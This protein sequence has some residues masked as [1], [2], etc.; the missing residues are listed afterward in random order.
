MWAPF[1]SE[2][3]WRVAQW[4]KMRGPGSNAFTELLEI[5]GV[6]TSVSFLAG[7][8]LILKLAACLGLSYTN[9]KELND[10]IDSHLP[11]RPEFKREEIKVKGEIFEIFYRDVIECVKALFGDEEL[12]PFI[13]L[14]PEKHYKDE[15]MSEQWYHN[16]HT[17]KWWWCT[18]VCVTPAVFSKSHT[19]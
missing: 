4:A 9:T 19:I 13:R 5:P 2:I 1:S 3:D 12:A 7:I 6:S 8:D 16:M 14:V 17:G 18:Q 11:G 15:T 10:I